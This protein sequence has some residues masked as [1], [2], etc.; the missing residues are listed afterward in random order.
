MRWLD[1]TAFEIESVRFE[2][3]IE[4][5]WPSSAGHF[6]LVKHR[7]MVERYVALLDELCPKHILELGV[8]QGGSAAFLW[9]YSA[10]ERLVTIDLKDDRVRALDDF[11]RDRHI[12]GRLRSH[13]SF[14]QS[15][16]ARLRTTLDA[17]FAEQPLDLVVDDASHRLEPTRASFNTCFPRLRP[18]GCYVIEDWSGL[19]LQDAALRKRASRDPAVAEKLAVIAALNQGVRQQSPL[20]VLLFEVILAAAYAPTA[21]AEV[22][23]ARDWARIVRGPA[24]LPSNFDLATAVPENMR[25]LLP[26]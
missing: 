7:E 16:G 10:P 5:R 12:E 21:F 18:G 4:H 20:S 13:Y 24:P 2:L 6:L 9:L 14:D 26:A 23:I 1:D 15:D 8:F 22:T 19:H 17:D 3:S 11:V 25:S